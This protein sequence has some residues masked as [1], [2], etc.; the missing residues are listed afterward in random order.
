MD[1][2]EWGESANHDSRACLVPF[3]GPPWSPTGRKEQ[4][5]GSVFLDYYDAE[6]L[7]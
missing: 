1:G 6:S 2:G 5:E 4:T 7:P 3:Y